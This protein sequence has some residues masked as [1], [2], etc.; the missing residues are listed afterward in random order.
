MEVLTGYDILKHVEPD[1]FVMSMRSFE[2]GLEW[3]QSR[4]AISSAYVMLVPNE[5][6]HAPYF[7]RLLKTRAYTS[8]LRR[9]S[10]LVRDGQA[11]RYANF[12]QIPLPRVPIG[13]QRAIASFLDK[14]LAEAG[15][16]VHRLQS[17]V[18]LLREYRTRLIADVVTGKLDVREW[19][20]RLPDEIEAPED[21]GQADAIE[22]SD[23]E[24]DDD[25]EPE[26]VGV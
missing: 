23:V 12:V 16:K 26:E 18:S 13:E 11:L 6:V 1:D 4:G 5:D 20:A 15:G 2:G 19:A 24:I 21:I 14:V 9:T 22:D 8:A 25:P 3:S 17:E 7:A 10:D